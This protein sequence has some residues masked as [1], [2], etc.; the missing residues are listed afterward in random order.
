M[1]P[2]DIEELKKVISESS[3]ETRIMI[4]CDSQKGRKKYR[5]TFQYVRVV[6]IHI[7]GKHG[8]QV[9]GESVRQRD[10]GNLK[11]RMLN[12]VYM[13]TDLAYNLMEAIGDRHLEIHVD[14]NTS[15]NHKSNVAMKEAVGFVKGMLGID[16]ILK[17]KSIAASCC[18]DHYCK[19]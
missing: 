10:F 3:K 16:P 4:G 2:I 12:E 17:P 18:A 6:I 1:K 13:A 19:G 9:Y 7:D 8:C 14:I 5:G 11:Q 15:P